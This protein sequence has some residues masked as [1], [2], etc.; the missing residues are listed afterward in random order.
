[1]S[2]KICGNCG[3]KNPSEVI[4]C[5]YCGKSDFSDSDK[6]HEQ[7]V[8]CSDCG[9]SNPITNRF[10]EE[11]GAFL[12]NTEALSSNNTANNNSYVYSSVDN[13]KQNYDCQLNQTSK[14]GNR[15]LLYVLLV[16]ICLVVGILLYK[17]I[18]FNPT[19]VDNSSSDAEFA[20]PSNDSSEDNYW[21]DSTTYSRDDYQITTT[22]SYEEK[23]MNGA[24]QQSY[25]DVFP[26]DVD[27][28]PSVIDI[29]NP[30]AGPLLNLRSGPGSKYA[31]IDQIENGEKVITLYKGK[32][33]Y[34]FCYY[35][36]ADKYG[37]LLSKYVK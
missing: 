3:S 9:S 4:Y 35:P 34:D 31:L 2:E 28:L 25:I 11:C 27:Y 16:V 10:C 7:V 19:I 22:Q 12:Q 30:Q 8:F 26:E 33:D 37:W 6:I 14:N 17:F 20:K 5:M 24:F 1:M 21:N 15:K 29:W 18:F 13:D 32:N 36:Q 23:I